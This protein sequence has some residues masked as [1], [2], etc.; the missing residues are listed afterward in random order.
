MLRAS[1][2]ATWDVSRKYPSA[3]CDTWN[4]GNTSKVSYAISSRI[5]LGDNWTDDM[6]EI[7]DS[8][9]I[10][11]L[12][13]A[14]ETSKVSTGASYC[15][16]DS[17][18]TCS[19][20]DRHRWLSRNN[21]TELLRTHNPQSTMTDG[22]GELISIDRERVEIIQIYA[23]GGRPGPGGWRILL[24]T[25]DDRIV[26]G[27]KSRRPSA[28]VAVIQ[29]QGTE[30]SF[31]TD[32]AQYLC[33]HSCHDRGHRPRCF[34]SRKFI[35]RPTVFDTAR[36]RNRWIRWH[37]GPGPRGPVTFSRPLG[38]GAGPDGEISEIAHE[39]SAQ[40][41]MCSTLSKH[42]VVEDQLRT[43]HAEQCRVR[44]KIPETFALSAVCHAFLVT[45][46]GGNQRPRFA[47][48][49]ESFT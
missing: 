3:F 48:L 21:F 23:D 12:S 37:W 29:A 39:G 40:R 20:L 13:A 46:L 6:R 15:V 27:S 31:G 24:A 28:E 4:T 35:V 26:F 42:P 9:G 45:V 18:T 41:R 19:S 36:Q 5:L 10:S 43:I 22:T 33:R 25:E 14:G 2:D 16:G 1:G 17:T 32:G 8:R 30:R 44:R 47:A 49:T 7:W 38:I 34:A 11:C